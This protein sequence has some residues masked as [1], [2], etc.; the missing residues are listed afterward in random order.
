LELEEVVASAERAELVLAALL[1]PVGDAVGDGFLEV[2]AGFD[3]FEI[4]LVAEPHRDGG[5]R[6]TGQD[7]VH[8]LGSELHATVP[9]EAGGD[10][11]HQLVHHTL[12]VA[13]LR[14]CASRREQAHPAVDVEAD[15]ARR[16]D[17]VGQRRGGDPPDGKAVAL[18]HVGHAEDAAHD[19]RKHGDVEELLEASTLGDLL[20]EH[21]VREDARAFRLEPDRTR[22]LERGRAHEGPH[23]S[24]TT[25]TEKPSVDSAIW[26]SCIVAAFTAVRARVGLCP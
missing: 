10:R 12:K 15:P 6:A 18:V 13:E 3:P 23:T 17:P 2:P 24:R 20:E 11:A 4:V 7:V 26:T 25:D 16:D 5:A 1:C 8:G 21:L 9:T 19:A 14:A 22:A